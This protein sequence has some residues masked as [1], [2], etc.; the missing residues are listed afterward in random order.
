MYNIFVFI[1]L[2]FYN[3]EVMIYLSK[4]ILEALQEPLS[5]IITAIKMALETVPPEL[6]ADIA[7]HGIVL[8]GGGALLQD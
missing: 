4:E 3:R 7:E 6:A 2:L 5:G 1:G 8:T